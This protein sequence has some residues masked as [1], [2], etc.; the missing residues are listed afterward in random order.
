MDIENLKGYVYICMAAS[1]WGLLGPFGKI[2]FEQGVSPLEV[3]FWRA[4]LAWLM[5]GSQAVIQR[6]IHVD[7]KDLP[8]LFLFGFVS[9]ALFFGSYQVAVDQCG[10]ALA[11]VLLYTA[12]VWVFLLSR[13]V[14]KERF[15]PVKISA[16]FITFTGVGLISFAQNAQSPGL[17]PGFSAVFIGLVAGFCYSLYYIMGKHYSKKYSAPLVFLYILPVGAVCLVPGF[18]FADKTMT[19]WCALGLIGFV[20]TYAAYHFYYAGLKRIEAGRA[21]IIATLEPVV[22]A[23]VAWFWWGE[24][25]SLTGYA[26]CLLILISVILIVRFK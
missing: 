7:K 9:V 23:V 1:L 19:A 13:I 4:F 5:F 18:T 16:L 8:G 22:A 6:T 20:S 11:A 17:R 2:A 24:H 3:A 21:S 10:V 15:T 12:P 25:F 26:G 14:F